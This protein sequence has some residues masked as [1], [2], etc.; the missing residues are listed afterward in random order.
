MQSLITG[1]IRAVFGPM[2]ESCPSPLAPEPE[3][4][5]RMFFE[6]VL[7]WARTDIPWRSWWDGGVEGPTATRWNVRG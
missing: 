1:E 4:Y 7:Y 3:V 6:A 2:V 5:D